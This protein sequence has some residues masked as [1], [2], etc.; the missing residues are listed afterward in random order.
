MRGSFREWTPK[1]FSLS[2]A[3][4]KGISRLAKNHAAHLAQLSTFTHG[5]ELEIYLTLLAY[6]LTSRRSSLPWKST[7]V[8]HSPLHL[9]D[10]EGRLSKP[11]R[12]KAQP[13][14]CYV[15]TGQGAQYA[16]MAKELFAFPVFLT[17]LRKSEGHF[18]DFGCSWS[19]LG[20]LCL[21]LIP[22]RGAM[23]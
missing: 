17:S 20:T 5:E 15:F 19:L 11:L 14:M 3:D 22:D 23:L 6:N 12:S 7:L 4:E 10:I 8:A 2:A 16:G 1:I 18:R 21:S 9:Q 13:R